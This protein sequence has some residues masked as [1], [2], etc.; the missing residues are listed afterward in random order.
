LEASYAEEGRLQSAPA[1]TIA[2]EAEYSAAG[3]VPRR[4]PS[5]PKTRF[6][7]LRYPWQRTEAALRNLA[8]D[9]GSESVALDFVNPETGEDPLPTIGFTA[10]MIRAGETTRPPLRSSSAVF[11]VVSGTGSTRIGENTFRWRSKDTFSAPGFARIEHFAQNSEAFLIEVH[12][13]PLQHR[14]GFYEERS[15]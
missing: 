9:A 8:N 10:L 11:H 2:S 13:R 6:P 1:R 3:L 4:N 12:D 14:L 15:V 7:V 5:R